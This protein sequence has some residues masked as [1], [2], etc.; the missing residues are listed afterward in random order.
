MKVVNLRKEK[1]DVYIGR[2]SKFGNPFPLANG[3][4]LQKRME[5]INKYEKWLRNQPELISQMKKELSGKVLGCYCKPLPCHGDIIIK[6]IKERG[7]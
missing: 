7:C 6:V 1:F 5:C 3:S 4:S 2:P